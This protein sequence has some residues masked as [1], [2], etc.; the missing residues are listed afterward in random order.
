MNRTLS[1]ERIAKKSQLHSYQR[2]EKKKPK[3]VEMSLVTKSNVWLNKQ[4]I[5]VFI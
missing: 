3:C 4:K 5:S 1:K 2:T